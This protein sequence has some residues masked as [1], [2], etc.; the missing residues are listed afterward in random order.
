MA[1]WSY[2]HPKDGIGGKR[3]TPGKAPGPNY[4]WRRMAG[5]TACSGN[6]LNF[7]E[8]TRAGATPRSMEFWSME[9]TEEPEFAIAG[10]YLSAQDQPEVAAAV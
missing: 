7:K 10:N 5:D 6:T 1:T 2:V 8:G 4:R 9:T 3:C